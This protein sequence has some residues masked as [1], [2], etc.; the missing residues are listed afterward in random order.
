M[1]LDIGNILFSLKISAWITFGFALF[2]GIIF[3]ANLWRFRIRWEGAQLA[4]ISISGYEPK[5]LQLI[6]ADL[7]RSYGFH[8]V[9]AQDGTSSL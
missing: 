1:N 2:M 3:W 7:L 9:N 8:P 4:R 6:L 5:A